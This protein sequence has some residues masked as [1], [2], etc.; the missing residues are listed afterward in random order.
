LLSPVVG[1]KRDAAAVLPINGNAAKD[2]PEI[3][4]EGEIKEQ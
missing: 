3:D 2:W 4:K 1:C